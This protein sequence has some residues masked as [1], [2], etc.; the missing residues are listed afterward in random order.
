MVFGKTFE[1]VPSTGSPEDNKLTLTSA[2]DQP[3]ELHVNGFCAFN[4]RSAR[5]K[6]NR[7]GV[8]N[9]DGGWGLG[10]DKLGTF[11]T[12]GRRLLCSLVGSP[13]FRFHGCAGNNLHDPTDHVDDTVTTGRG[14]GYYINTI[15]GLCKL[16]G[17]TDTAA[18]FRSGE[19]E[20][21]TLD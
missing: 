18:G 13:N 12:N 8:I 4:F 1:E 14:E 19:V 21:L 15:R 10:V 7:R 9:H 3:V 5:G 20:S 11:Q 16:V 6:S 17:D 2:F